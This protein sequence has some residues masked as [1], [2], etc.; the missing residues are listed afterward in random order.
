MRHR[1][2]FQASIS[3][4]LGN[5]SRTTKSPTPLR[6]GHGWVALGVLRAVYVTY[7]E[8][9]LSISMV[10]FAYLNSALQFQAVKI[11]L[12]CGGRTAEGSQGVRGEVSM[13]VSETKVDYCVPLPLTVA[14][15]LL[16]ISRGIGEE[17]ESNVLLA[18]PLFIFPPP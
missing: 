15:L 4:G 12:T 9:G 10:L 11:L 18:S 13:E 7:A 5:G 6:L 14:C 2:T 3:R 8:H 17:K 16:R 1:Y